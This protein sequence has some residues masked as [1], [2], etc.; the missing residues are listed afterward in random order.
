MT[1]AS[2]GRILAIVHIIIGFLLFCF[3]IADRV[4][5]YSFTGYVGF[6]IWIGIWVSRV[7]DRSTVPFYLHFKPD[8]LNQRQDA[9]D[10]LCKVMNSVDGFLPSETSNSRF[11]L[12]IVN[13]RH[14]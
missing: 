12:E 11:I 1:N 10:L 9:F 13:D 7:C 4:L 6:G 5:E 8:Y 3:G 14:N 2:M